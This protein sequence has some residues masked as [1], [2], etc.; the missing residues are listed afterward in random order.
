MV[1]VPTDLEKAIMT[2]K[3]GRVR[4]IDVGCVTKLDGEKL[5]NPYYFLETAG[6]GIEADIQK[7]GKEFEKGNL[8]SVI[9]IIK[10]L[11]EF[12]SNKVKIITDEGEIEDNATL[13]SVANG[14]YT[15]AALKLSPDAKL[16]DHRLH[17][18]L[19]KMD[20]LEMAKYFL[21]MKILGKT[22]KRRLTIIKTKK[23]RIIPHHE[24]PIHADATLFGVTPAEFKIVPNAIQVICG[25]P[26]SEDESYLL[27]R[28]ILD[29]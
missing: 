6:F 28:T 3:I 26:E 21:K 29:P 9:S 24:L 4:K 2:I 16:N 14:P 23:V 1:S 18:T 25:F 10:T 20:K 12:Y 8:M 22:D 5:S 17:V 15:G 11:K 19:Y 13:I 27:S 7:Y